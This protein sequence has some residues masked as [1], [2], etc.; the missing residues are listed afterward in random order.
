MKPGIIK[1]PTSGYIAAETKREEME[2]S[3]YMEAKEI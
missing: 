1:C 3:G 2:V